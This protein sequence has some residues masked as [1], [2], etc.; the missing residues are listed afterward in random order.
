M[1]DSSQVKNKDKLTIA[2]LWEVFQEN[3]ICLSYTMKTMGLSEHEERWRWIHKEGVESR[4]E[5]KNVKCLQ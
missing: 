5:R 1:V 3:N 4:K 2:A